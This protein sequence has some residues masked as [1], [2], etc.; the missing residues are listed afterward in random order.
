[1]ISRAASRRTIARS[2]YSSSRTR[3]RSIWT[4]SSPRAA[5]ALPLPPLSVDSSSR[6]SRALIET[7]SSARQAVAQPAA[8]AQQLAASKEHGRR[9]EEAP[10]APE[11]SP[12]AV[13]SSLLPAGRAVP[14]EH[15]VPAAAASRPSEQSRHPRRRRHRRPRQ[16]P[17]PFQ[18]RVLAMNCHFSDCPQV[19][20]LPCRSSTRRRISSRCWISSQHSSSCLLSY[21]LHSKLCQAARHP[22]HHF[23]QVSKHLCHLAAG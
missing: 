7:P 19:H 13:A 21:G 8:A 1:M 18:K 12:R 14:R 11:P 2:P 22:G 15:L 17:S 3:S 5:E 4:A 10:E 16:Q 6:R 20:L 9:S 23:C